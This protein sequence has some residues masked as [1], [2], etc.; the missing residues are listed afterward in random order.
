M[1]EN[2]YFA[3]EH[4]LMLARLTQAACSLQVMALFWNVERRKQAYHTMAWNIGPKNRRYV[5]E[6]MR[7][8]PAFLLIKGRNGL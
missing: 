6:R 2:I 5:F 4:T 3:K 1:H 7:L 8:L